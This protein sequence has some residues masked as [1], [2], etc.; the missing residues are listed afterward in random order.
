M[1]GRVLR[2]SD[3]ELQ[4]LAGRASGG[5]DSGDRRKPHVC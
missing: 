4:R 1:E 2:A 3:L 5:I